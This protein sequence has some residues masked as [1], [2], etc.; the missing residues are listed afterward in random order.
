MR[1][2]LSAVAV[3]AML[4]ASGVRSGEAARHHDRSARVDA[5]H[6]LVAHA[7]RRSGALPDLRIGAFVAPE[8]SSEPRPPR[9]NALA[10]FTIVHGAPA[11]QPVSAVAR[12]PPEP[13][14]L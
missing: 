3:V 9:T 6:A 11:P 14:I 8:R 7:A 2:A 1:W 5:A 13:A 12:G 10:S 4:V